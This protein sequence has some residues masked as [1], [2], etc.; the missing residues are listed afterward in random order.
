M[1]R[2]HEHRDVVDEYVG[3]RRE[4]AGHLHIL[5]QKHIS[6]LARSLAAEMQ[7]LFYGSYEVFSLFPL[8]SFLSPTFFT[9]L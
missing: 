6:P 7:R 8:L 4:I 5:M 3:Y 2:Q 1:C 9:K